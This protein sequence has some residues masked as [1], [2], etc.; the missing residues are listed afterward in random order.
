MSSETSQ[1]I[2]GIHS[3]ECQLTMNEISAVLEGRKVAQPEEASCLFLI[4]ISSPVTI[5]N[6]QITV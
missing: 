2:Y 6:T 4:T 3:E 1:I 5:C